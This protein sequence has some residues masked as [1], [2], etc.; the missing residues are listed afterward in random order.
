MTGGARWMLPV[1]V[2]LWIA[3]FAVL[4]KLDDLGVWRLVLGFALIAAGILL[5][6]Q[7]RASMSRRTTNA[8]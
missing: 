6:R 5:D 8:D 7:R 3:G 1:V 2:L 4:I